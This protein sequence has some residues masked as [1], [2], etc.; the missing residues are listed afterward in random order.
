MMN[1][2][3]I[4][5]QLSQVGLSSFV[6]LLAS[7]FSK[8]QQKRVA[9]LTNKSLQEIL[10]L[11]DVK[12]TND[13]TKSVNIY[14]AAIQSSGIRD[15]DFWDY[16]YRIGEEEV[17]GFENV[18]PNLSI[19]EQIEMLESLKKRV[20]G[21]MT[22]IEISGDL[23]DPFNVH[24]IQSAH[25]V[26]YVFN[27]SPNSMRLLKAFISTYDQEVVRKTGF[28]C[29]KYDRNVISE[30]SLSKELGISQYRIMQVPY[31]SAIC[32]KCFNGTLNYVARH[33]AMGHY[34]VAELRMKFLEI[35]QYLYDT[36]SRKYIKGIAEW[37][38]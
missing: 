8:T 36:K 26:L 17:Y 4:S 37:K 31:N 35:M 18:R 29:T 3:V 11:N 33:V 14:R 30:K 5:N 22:L 21:D 34:E 10:E 27:H 23:N 13:S 25:L 12:V 20:N 9:I 38:A 19:Q 24:A 15:E 16:G 1:I 7:I 32:N 2:A 6:S 28:V